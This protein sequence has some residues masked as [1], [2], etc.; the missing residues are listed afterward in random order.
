[1]Y[2]P[3]YLI[4]FASVLIQSF[5]QAYTTILSLISPTRTGRIVTPHVSTLYILAFFYTAYES[6][7]PYVITRAAPPSPHFTGV[8]GWARF[9]LLGVAGALI[10][11]LVPHPLLRTLNENESMDQ[12]TNLNSEEIASYASRL[13]FSYLNPII[14]KAFRV[15]HLGVDQLP[16]LLE[17][18]SA[19]Y[20]AE[21]AFP[22]IDPVTR[23]I[24]EK[25]RH[26]F[27]SL[28]KWLWG[29][30]V[31]MFFYH[32]IQTIAQFMAPISLKQLLSALELPCSSPVKPWL[33]IV[34]IALGP[35]VSSLMEQRHLVFGTRIIVHLEAVFT[36]LVFE[37]SLR[38]HLVA[39]GS[40]P[41]G[42]SEEEGVATDISTSAEIGEL[43]ETVANL[44]PTPTEDSSAPTSVKKKPSPIQCAGKSLLGVM[45]N[46]VTTDLSIIKAPASHLLEARE[47]FNF[48]C[49][50]IWM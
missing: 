42:T 38:I 30:Y 37:H 26:I 3:F 25:N 27:W 46:L 16:P 33:W 10:P 28:S 34:L 44:V 7:K 8:I 45:T 32:T 41:G 20:L 6:L 50:V 43:D 47:W 40:G 14:W 2:V 29:D 13:T 49:I 17:K 9:G 31:Q 1:M 4:A 21:K 48:A 11:L 24:T 23:S 18:D 22:L 5:V 39:P 12:I 36:Q 19:R 15:P 35:I